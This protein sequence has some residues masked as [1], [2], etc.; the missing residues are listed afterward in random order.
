MSVNFQTILVII[1]GAFAIGFL[2]K[3]YVLKPKKNSS[4]S[5]GNDGCGC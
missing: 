1:I 2:V 3:K 5:C 4:K